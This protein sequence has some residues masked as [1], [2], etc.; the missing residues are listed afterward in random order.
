MAMAARLCVVGL[1]ALLGACQTLSG[2]KAPEVNLSSIQLESV[3]MF[4]QQWQVVLRARN[5]NDRDLTLESLDYELYV[6]GHKLA[7]GLT[8]QPVTLPAMGDALVP[9]EVTTSL[10]ENL[11][12]LQD[13]QSQPGAPVHY[14]IKGTARVAGVMFP[15]HFDHKGQ[16]ALPAATLP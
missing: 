3:T 5:P 15:V 1:L 16:I 7:R 9:T 14:E 11:G 12:Q 10:L 8:G 2:L 4:E 6:N 13:M